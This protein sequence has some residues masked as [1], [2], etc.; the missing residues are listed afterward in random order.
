MLSLGAR[1]WYSCVLLICT[2]QYTQCSTRMQPSTR[3]RI[4]DVVRT[5]CVL[6][7]VCVKRAAARMLLQYTRCTAVVGSSSHGHASVIIRGTVLCTAATVLSS[8]LLAV[9]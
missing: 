2:V 7:S 4:H 6:Y 8:V 9:Q 1:G 3:P 5:V